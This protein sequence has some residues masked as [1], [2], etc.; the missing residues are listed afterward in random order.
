MG[1]AAH[2]V[3]V[4][5]L[6]KI[7]GGEIG[8]A[9]ERTRAGASKDEIRRDLDSVVAVSDVSFTVGQGQI[10]VVM[11]LSGSGKS[12]L[13]RCIN[14][15]IEPTSGQVY[16]DAED[17]VAADEKRLR[18]I[19]LSKLSMV[20][21]HFALFP[22]MTVAENVEYGLKVK[23]AP[24]E[25]R[26]ETALAA[27]DKVGLADWAD[28][29]PVNLSGGMQQR[30]GLARALAVGPEVLLMDEP[31][32]ALDPLIR[33]DMQEELI[34]LQRELKMT[35]VFITH[36]LHEAL[37]LGDRVAIMKDGRFVQVGSPEEIVGAPADDYVSAFTQ[38]VDRG[39][40]FTVGSVME[41]PVAADAATESPRTALERMRE[42]GWQGLIVTDGGRPVGIVR[43]R[44]A[45][46]AEREGAA[47]LRAVMRQDFPMAAERAHLA[48]IYDLCA[49]GLPIAVLDGE[50]ALKGVVNPLD[51]LAELAGEDVGEGRSVAPAASPGAGVAGTAAGRRGTG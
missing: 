50:G 3:R 45:L 49:A 6:S 1:E 15:L 43:R 2:K 13:V 17:V 29:P 41:A 33:K 38:D 12:T 20:F 25:A 19:R 30:V 44:D 21:Q 28:V 27:L 16:L 31:F 46:S 48:D 37:R 26:R 11:G 39:R 9:L 47:D 23:G 7:F 22:H 42:L 4:E 34:V 24:P 5:H 32:S 35:I 18:E 10:F 8:A 51:V 40:V 36:D 14:R